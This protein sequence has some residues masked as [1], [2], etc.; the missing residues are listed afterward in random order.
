MFNIACWNIRGVNV[1][2]KQNE[3]KEFLRKQDIAICGLV[4]TH[5]HGDSLASI[6]NRTFGKW[7]GF[8]TMH[9]LSLEH[10]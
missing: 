5:L 6:C 4:K 9:F 1:T 8:Q 7:S 10:V 3:V 2:G